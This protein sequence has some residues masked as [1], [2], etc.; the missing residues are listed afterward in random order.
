MMTE[1]S[2]VEN[3]IKNVSITFVVQIVSYI[4]V[5]IS[6]TFFV[7]LLGNDYLSLN[8]LF[9]NI[10]TLLS[11]TDLGI[12]SAVVYCLYKPI[13]E[14]DTPKILALI[15]FFKKIYSIITIIV[16]VLGACLI[17]FL[18]YLVD[19]ET[20]SGISDNIYII[21]YLFVINTAFSY[22]LTY[23]KSFLTA[24]QKN[25]VVNVIHYSVYAI[26]LLIQIII[27][28]VSHNYILYL[29]VQL[30]CTLLTNVISSKYVDRKYPNILMK[31]DSEV[32]IDEKKDIWNNVGSM[33][34]YK[35]G[36]VVLN[37]T[38]NIIISTLIRTS[39]VG[40]CSNYTLIIQAINNT[41]SMCFNSIAASVGNLT[42]TESPKRQEE[43]F[44]QL[45]LLAFMMFGFCSICLGVLLNPLIN[46]WFGKEYLLNQTVV[47]SLVAAFYFTGINQA[48]YLFRTATGLFKQAKV[49]PFLAAVANIVLSIILAKMIGLAGVFIATAIV[50]IVFFMI[51]DTCLIYKHVFKKTS[52][53]YYV[54][55]IVKALV[56]SSGY[57]ITNFIISRCEIHNFVSLVLYAI[58]CAMIS[59]FYILIWC[60]WNPVF[61]TLFRKIIQSFFVREKH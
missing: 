10:I 47:A 7:K 15:R 2:R 40:L 8:G 5:F 44:Y 34:F 50:R 57:V 59:A 36:S 14:N 31:S 39:F 30:L 17:P 42:V 54:N 37:G 23:K 58:V 38:D 61:K 48:S 22:I 56:I 11:F 45:D 19:L 46:I 26:Q 12:G 25:Y 27:L 49:Y 41:L 16:L 28:T 6:R 29:L 9:S 13:A 53:L 35:I 3:S 33:F 43:V 51:V 18:H 21:Y 4:L 55:F 20:V 32:S 1:Q 52:I 24:C 60:S